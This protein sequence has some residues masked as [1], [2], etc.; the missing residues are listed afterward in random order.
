MQINQVV[1]LLKFLPIALTIVNFASAFV[2]MNSCKSFT[3]PG[4]YNVMVNCT[5]LLAFTGGK[6]KLKRK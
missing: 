5:R 1:V 2:F 6:Y 3:V 4:T